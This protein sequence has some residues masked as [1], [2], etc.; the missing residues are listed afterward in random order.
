MFN[1][2]F[3]GPTNDAAPKSGQLAFKG[4]PLDAKGKPIILTPKMF[5]VLF[6]GRKRK[7]R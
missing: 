4:P 7:K 6:D 5:D 3:G 1:S 2:I